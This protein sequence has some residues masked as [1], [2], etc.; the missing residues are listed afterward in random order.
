MEG[1]QRFYRID[2]SLYTDLGLMVPDNCSLRI[3]GNWVTNRFPRAAIRGTTAV[4]Y[5]SSRVRSSLGSLHPDHG[6]LDPSRYYGT[7]SPTWIAWQEK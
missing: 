3:L 4:D 1:G 2:G 7:L 5:L 6:R